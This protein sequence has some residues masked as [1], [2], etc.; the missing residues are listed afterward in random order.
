MIGYLR[1]LL[2]LN[3]WALVY[4]SILFEYIT[5]L[6]D[7]DDEE[8]DAALEE[9]EALKLQKQM[10]EQLDDQDFGLDIFQVGT[11]KF[12]LTLVLLNP[13]IPCFCKQ[14]R[15]RSVGFRSQLTWIYSV[16]QLEFEFVSITWIK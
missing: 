2:V 15:S 16:C 13:I 1:T 11:H 9:K 14:C 4:Y 7:I 6:A 8:G 3:N 12:F 5:V 10:A